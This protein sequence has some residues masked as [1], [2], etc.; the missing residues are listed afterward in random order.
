M[1]SRRSAARRSPGGLSRE[2]AARN[3]TVCLA[4]IGMTDRTHFNWAPV[5]LV[6]E[7]ETLLRLKADEFLEDAGF[8]VVDAADAG[9]ALQIMAARPDVTVL[10][11][12]IEL[13]GD[14]DGIE[15]ARLVHDRWTKVLLLVT[16]ARGKPPQSQIADD[17]HFLAKPYGRR[18]VVDE[19]RQM[20]RETRERKPRRSN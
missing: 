10:F 13:P 6:V 9:E 20:V 16:S 18:N 12:D 2:A 8:E 1:K 4:L 19:I 11:T 7:D 17:G 15:L 5:V 3:P 14:L